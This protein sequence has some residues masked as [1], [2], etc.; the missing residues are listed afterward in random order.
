MRRVVFSLLAGA[1]ALAL[2]AGSALADGPGQWGH[3][4]GQYG[5]SVVA[6]AGTITSVDPSTGSFTANAFIPSGEGFGW[7]R[8]EGDQGQGSAGQGSGGQGDQGAQGSNGQGSDAQAGSAQSQQPM[9]HADVRSGSDVF[10]QTMPASTPET[11]TTD[12][13]TTYKV[14]GQ[15]AAFSDLQPGDRFVALYH[16]APTDSIATLVAGP[17]LAVFAHSAATEHQLYAFTGT[18]SAIDTSAGTVT[19]SLA[20]TLPAGLGSGPATFTLSPA[21]MIL[22]GTSTNGL[23]GGSASDL[24]VGDVVAGGEVGPAGQTLSQVEASPLQVL[25]DFPG[26]TTA[27]TSSV[28]KLARARALTQAEALFGYRAGRHAGRRSRHHHKSRARAHR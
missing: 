9:A 3:G 1:L 28:R 11:I 27:S 23:W 15:D 21:T 22:G 4:D 25:V 2:G 19:V 12:S 6:V 7:H 24:K 14:D 26:S 8:G 16:G 10:G 13:S 5:G 20:S 18:L 17:A